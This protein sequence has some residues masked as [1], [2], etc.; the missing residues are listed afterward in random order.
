MDFVSKQIDFKLV[1]RCIVI[2]EIGVNHNNDS[3]IL[4]KLIDEGIKAGVDIV[5][6]QR[7]SAEAEIS[8]FAPKAEYQTFSGPSGESQLEMAKKLQL[9]DELIGKAFEYCKD[10]KIGFLCAAFD[11]ESVDFLADKLKCKTLKVPSPEL[12]N[13]PLLKHMARKFPSLLL[14]TGASYLSECLTAVELL[15]SLGT[16]DLI[17]MHCVSEY[18]APIEDA[19]L[20]AIR[21][22]QKAT[23]LPIGYSDHTQGIIAPIVAATLGA[24]VVEKHYTLDKS[25]LGPD[26]KASADIQELTIMVQAIRDACQSLGSGL[27]IPASSEFKNR[28]IIRKSLVSN[29][30]FL[31]E[32]TII[33]QDMLAVKRP[34]ILGAILP[35]D[36]DKVIGMKLKKAKVFDEPIMWDDFR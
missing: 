34:E 6:L 1:D 20:L 7:F 24:V 19:N 26:H 3:D 21:T 11:H 33:T 13:I 36:F 15:N 14:S 29:V 5:K 25:M 27:K 10:R 16:K 17:L 23:H 22:L 28:P 18:P 32:G 31:Q 12:T 35:I 2:G 4:F 30:E 9:T 8:T